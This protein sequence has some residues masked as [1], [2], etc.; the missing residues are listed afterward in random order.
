MYGESNFSIVNVYGPNSDNEDF[1]KSLHHLISGESE[2]PLI[3]GGDMNTVLDPCIDRYPNHTQYHPHCKVE[4]DVMK[5]DFDLIDIWRERNP[6]KLQFTWRS[7]TSRSRIDYFLISRN[8]LNFV[9]DCNIHYGFKSDHSAIS[10]IV[11][12]NVPQRGPGYW[13]LNVSILSKESN[14]LEIR[15]VIEQTIQEN[16]EMNICNLWEFV[17]YQVKRKCIELSKTQHQKLLDNFK[18]LGKKIEQ[19]QKE[20][21]SNPENKNLEETLLSKKAELESMQEEMVRGSMIRTRALWIS[22]GEKNTKY[23]YNLEKRNY[24]KKHIQKLTVENVTLTDPTEILD[25][26]KCFYENLYKSKGVK[27]EDIVH[28]LDDLEIPC[29]DDDTSNLCEGLIVESECLEAI[30]SMSLDK[31]PGNDGL[32]L[33]FYKE[34][35]KDIKDL[36]CRVFNEFFVSGEMSSTLKTGIITLLPKKDKNNLLLKNWRPISLLNTD[37]KI[38][39]KILANRLKKV[40]PHIINFD[41]SG[42]LKGR[43]IGENIR[44]FLDI[45]DYCKINFLKGIALSIDFEKAFDSIEWNFLQVCLQKFGFKND[46]I[47]WINILYK[48]IKS[49]VINNG[50]A[51]A[52]FYLQRG[53]RQGCP[54]SPYLFIL[55]VEIL[56]LLVR[57]NQDIK[58]IMI[59]NTEIKISQYA[60]DTIIYLSADNTNLRNTFK[61]LQTFSKISGLCINIEKSNIVRLG[62]QRRI[63]CEDIKINWLDDYITY[64]GIHIPIRKNMDCYDLNFQKK[65]EE[66]KKVLNVWRCR[67][68]TLIGKISIVKTLIIPK[69]VYV[70]SIIKNPP[71]HFF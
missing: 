20:F 15:K 16:F 63:L 70:F 44:L 38:L 27:D 49:C 57:Q 7:H 53:V 10:L 1:F 68:L 51:S 3:I 48:D 11:L 2:E 5:E 24:N 55:G 71:Q 66:S 62:P 61:L 36:L 25:A 14:R 45:I 31:T 6:D 54:L 26:E 43:F 8:L 17:K 41:Q 35:W 13:K 47:R 34:F 39:A 4:I 64:L 21:D 58:G 60:D 67:N 46:L 52:S 30:N 59:K 18:Y 50:F 29:L 9:E 22:E 42:F 69:C 37:Y 40:L 33:N 12:K 32:P 28:I 23:F 65:L 56:G 19:L